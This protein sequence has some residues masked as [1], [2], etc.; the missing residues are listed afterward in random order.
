MKLTERD[1]KRLQGCDPR[2]VKIIEYAAEKT[3]QSFIVNEGKR[4]IETQTAYYAQGRQSLDEVNRLRKIAGLAPINEAT[5][6]KIVTK[7]M[8]SKHIKGIAADLYPI[9]AG[10]VDSSKTALSRVADAMKAG[11]KFYNVQ[12]DGGFNWGWDYY[13]YELKL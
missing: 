4:T 12:I 9:T 13:H 7:T 10:R 2:L 3:L 6:K 8:N 11:A 1:Y 5:N